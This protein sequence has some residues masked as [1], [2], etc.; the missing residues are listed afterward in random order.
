MSEMIQH[1]Q[2]AS[3]GNLDELDLVDLEVA[4]RELEISLM[5]MDIAGNPS[6]FEA[7]GDGPRLQMVPTTH[8]A[9]FSHSRR[10]P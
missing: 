7:G 1:L 6:I 10:G 2:E 8:E 4:V 9:I 3:D 5:T